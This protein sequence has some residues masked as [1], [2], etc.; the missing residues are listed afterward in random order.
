MYDFLEEI[1]CIGS[2][3]LH[4]FVTTLYVLFCLVLPILVAL[5]MF[6]TVCYYIIEGLKW[7]L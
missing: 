3:T 2:G 5:G 7:I 4:V 1:A 6:F